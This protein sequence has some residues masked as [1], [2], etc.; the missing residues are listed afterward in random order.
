MSMATPIESPLLMSP[1]TSSLSSLPSL[2]SLPRPNLL[3]S[4]VNPSPAATS[5]FAPPLASSASPASSAAL[6]TT[7]PPASSHSSHTF[8][9][10]SSLNI[11]NGKRIDKHGFIYIS[12]KGDPESRGYAQGFLLAD[13]IVK[14]IRTYAFFLWNEYGRDITFF[15]KMIN[16]LFGPIVLKQYNEYYLEMKGIARGV[17]DQILKLS[18]KQDKDKYFTDGAVDGNKIVLP[19]DSHLD[20]SNLAYNNAS[21]EETQKYTTTGKILI[22]PNF[23]IIFLLNCIVTVDYVYGKLEDIFNSNKYLQ[24]SSVYKEYFRSLQPTT[25]S[26]GTGK[27]TGKFFNLFRGGENSQSQS[28]GASDR[29]SAFMAIGEKYTA[30]G[31]IVGAH[32]TFDNFVMGQFDNIILFMDTSSSH[33][34]QKPSYNILMQ[35]FP[36]SIFS[37]TDFFITSAKMM[38]TETTIGGFNAFELHAPSCVR[39]RKAMQY[40]GTLDD[41]IK[42]FRENNSGDYANTWY[43]GHT[44]SKDPD[45][46]KERAEIMRIELGLKYVHIEKKTDGYFIGFN[47]CYDPRIRNLECKNHGYFDIRRHVGARRVALDMKIKEYTEGTKRISPKEAQLILSSHWDVYLEKENP[48]S[49]TICSHYELDKRE[50]MSQENRPKPYQPRGAVDGKICTS[51]LCNNMQ[52]L[53]RWGNACGTDFKRDDFCNRHAQWNYQ[54]AYLEDRLQKPWVICSSVN[55][56]K[57]NSVMSTAIKE[58]DSSSA[59]GMGSASGVGSDSYKSSADINMNPSRPLSPIT[60][61]PSLPSSPPSMPPTSLPPPSLLNASSSQIIATVPITASLLPPSTL[62][63]PSPVKTPDH[64]VKQPEL[65]NNNMYNDDNLLAIG[66]SHEQV[67]EFDNKKELKEFIK[68][69]KKQNRKSYKSKNSNT[70]RNKKNDK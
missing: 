58:Y 8:S 70:R 12:V 57:P 68:M 29:C 15:T 46:G 39:C 30:G 2:P 42:Y 37:S 64:P 33:T 59:S 22:D 53:A 13:R 52:F 69:F 21:R 7:F 31:G 65:I 60:P 9:S 44:A 61:S 67:K 55:I 17:A 43:I 3:L 6:T 48:C 4:S 10:Q 5:S 36:G 19:A 62:P 56:S 23:D 40:S 16:D 32:I 1:T 49:R 28:G 38:G 27:L 66:G 14:L 25:A 11:E 20:K 63:T 18:T 26:T 41:Y 34:P 51:E 54:R 24:K 47:A 50:Y 45:T 35:T